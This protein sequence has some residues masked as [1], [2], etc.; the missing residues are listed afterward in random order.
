VPAISIGFAVNFL[1]GATL[2]CLAFWT[3]RI[4]SLA[5]FF[6]AVRVLF[7]GQFVPLELMP[8]FIQQAAQFLPFQ[9]TRYFPIQLILNKL[10]A[11]V[12]MRDFALDVIWLVISMIL[13]RLV[14]REGVKRYSAV[15]A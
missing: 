4:Y 12:V 7:S 5:E 15:G 8:P 13:F 14:W 9:L 1:F 6:W 3:T 2:T 10:P 11:E